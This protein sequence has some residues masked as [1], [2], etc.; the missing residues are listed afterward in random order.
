MDEI[1]KA[2]PDIF[3]VLLQVL[4]EGRLTDR[5]GRETSFRNTIIILTSNIG[6]RQLQEFGAG[7]GFSAGEL[8]EDAA[9]STLLKALRKTFPPEF[10]NRMDDIISFR[11][12]TRDTLSDILDI[13]IEKLV[14]RMK[15]QNRRLVVSPEAKAQL[16]EKAYDP[17]YGAR[18]IRRAVQT[19]LE[20]EITRRLLDNPEKRT[21]TISKLNVESAPSK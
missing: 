11:P 3:N 18:P 15:E 7:V 14:S 6:T 21:L 1:E 5:Q 9:Q 16:L 10:V 4:D 19:Y 12:L 17:Q 20:D 13:E 2:H 8:T